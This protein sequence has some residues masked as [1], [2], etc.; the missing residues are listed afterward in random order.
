MTSPSSRS[1]RRIDALSKERIVDAA[2]AILDAD[3][4]DG[5]ALTLRRLMTRLETGSG[6]IYHHV[7]TMDEL[8]AAAADQVL[9]PQFEAI[10]SESEPNDALRAVARA[11]FESIRAH[12]WIGAQL[13]RS[14][15]QD[16]VIRIWKTIGIQLERLGL[17]GAAA[18]TAGSTL[19]SFVLGSVAQFGAGPSRHMGAADRR[20]Y[21]ETLA[22]EWAQLDGDIVVQDIA[23]QL[24]EHDDLQ[25]FLDG[26]DLILRGIAS[27]S[28]S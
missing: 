15:L 25:Q 22:Q 9:R 20:E 4:S 24:R 2:I 27:G 10:S 11:I 17:R 18:A 16:A 19:T 5:A 26:V 8:R 28:T 14:P 21:L 3:E 23:S 12:P 7:A 6:A 13:T 1:A